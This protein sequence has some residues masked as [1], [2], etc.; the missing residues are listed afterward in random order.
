MD[1][2]DKIAATETGDK[3]KPKTDIRIEKIEIIKE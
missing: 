3:D 2:V 1:V